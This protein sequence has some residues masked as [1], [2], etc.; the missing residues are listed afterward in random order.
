MYLP[1]DARS[2]HP[3]TKASSNML[4]AGAVAPA[5]KPPDPR[6]GVKIVALRG[7]NS[8]LISVENG[9]FNAGG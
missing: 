1:A 8:V 3:I 7:P 2:S 4:T 5:V 9:L 6:S